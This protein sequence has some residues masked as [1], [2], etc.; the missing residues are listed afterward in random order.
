MGKT[1]PKGKTNEEAY[2]NYRLYG[3]PGQRDLRTIQHLREYTCTVRK[4]SFVAMLAGFWSPRY[5]RRM[6]AIDRWKIDDLDPVLADLAAKEILC[7]RHRANNAMYEMPKELTDEQLA[8]ANFYLTQCRLDVSS[9]N[10]IPSYGPSLISLWTDA[11][12]TG[13]QDEEAAERILDWAY[14]TPPAWA[15]DDERKKKKLPMIDKE[16][17]ARLR[18]HVAWRPTADLFI[19][20]NSEVDG[21]RW[22]VRINDFPDEYMYSLL[23]DGTLIG[24]FHDWPEPW[25]R[26][27]VKLETPAATFARPPVAVHAAVSV[28]ATRLVARYQAGECEAV[29]RDL[30]A[31]GSDVRKPLYAAATQAVA[32]E[33]MRRTRHNFDLIVERLR[34]IDYQFFGG[35]WHE[36]A[37]REDLET[38]AECEREALWFPVSLRTYLNEF[39]TISLLG[40]HP[41]LSPIGFASDPLLIGGGMDLTGLLEEW[42]DSDP[43]DRAPI[44]FELCPDARSKVGVLDNVEPGQLL[45]IQLPN[46]WADAVLIGEPQERTLVEYLRWSFQWGGFPGWEKER[47]RPDKELAFLRNGLL[48]I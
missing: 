30:A 20:W 27:S 38:L 11:K 5:F 36:P 17:Q 24:D 47:S 32:K 35:R 44:L 12:A 1:A 6:E 28:D 29:W 26:G 43:Q 25:D 34:S 37:S 4:E 2:A 39:G 7:A 22:E 8:S 15:R 46:N 14:Q 3:E 41:R 16:V 21:Q 48:P 18:Q 10:E 9:L 13:L 40:T 31:L 45:Y 19:P 23:I 42:T 33:T